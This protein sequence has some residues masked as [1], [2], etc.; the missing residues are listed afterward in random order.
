VI[1]QLTILVAGKVVKE[2]EQSSCQ[3]LWIWFKLGIYNNQHIPGFKKPRVFFKKS[4]TQW[5]F[6]GFIGFLVF[7]GFYWGL[8]DKQEKIGK[9]IQKLS[10][11]KA[12]KALKQ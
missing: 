10:N 1:F 2:R 11:L 9:I 12:L 7:I 5:L 4:P 6:L 8:L 3:L